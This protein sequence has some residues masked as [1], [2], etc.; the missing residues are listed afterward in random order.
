MSWSPDHS[1]TASGTA[2]GS[3]PWDT[4]VSKRSMEAGLLG[5]VLEELRL[6]VGSGGERSGSATAVSVVPGSSVEA[7]SPALRVG[8]GDLVTAARRRRAASCGASAGA[9]CPVVGGATSGAAVTVGAASSPSSASPAV[10]A[11]TVTVAN[12]A[13]ATNAPMVMPDLPNPPRIAHDCPAF[14]R[15]WVTGRR[16]P[17]RPLTVCQAR[18]AN[19][20][21]HRILR[22][23][24]RSGAATQN[25]RVAGLAWRRIAMSHSSEPVQQLVAR[26]ALSGCSPWCCWP[27]S[28]GYSS[29]RRRQEPPAHGSTRRS[30]RRSPPPTRR[31]WRRP[32][33]HRATAPSAAGHGPCV[34]GSSPSVAGGGTAGIAR[35]G[36]RA[37]RRRAAAHRELT[38]RH[39]PSGAAT[40]S[41]PRACAPPPSPGA[42]V[43]AALAARLPA[44]ESSGAEN[45]ASFDVP[46]WAW[47]ALDRRDRR[48][49][50]RRPPPRAPHRARHQHQGGGDRV[51]HLDLDRPRLRRD[52][53]RSGRAARPAA[54]TTPASSSRRAC[55][56]TTSSCG[57]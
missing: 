42:P 25:R 49:A 39:S 37:I 45:F 10:A 5:E 24:T 7:G 55:P 52:H 19:G 2:S 36:H 20:V 33:A 44:A 56:S 46:L 27:S 38:G 54:S 4:D 34:A 29:W 31:A 8:V 48:H 30:K 11:R 53:D 3:T 14:A 6:A 22:P 57:P 51:R 16:R 32:A 40:V 1:W 28:A 47:L 43:I 13:P 23:S 12:A 21:D 26:R 35:A 17:V 18:A 15:W 50:R 41:R 9:G